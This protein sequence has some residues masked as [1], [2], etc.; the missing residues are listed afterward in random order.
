MLRSQLGVEKSEELV[1]LRDRGDS[2]LASTSG[3]SLF[4]RHTRWQSLDPVDIGFLELLD[5]LTGVR[6]HAV[7]ESALPF[8]EEDVE[9]ER[10]LAAATEPRHDDHLIAGDLDGDVLEV[11]LARSV[12]LDRL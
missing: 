7:E 6:R 3:D 9:C 12:D 10:R 8:G 2:R 11:V 4:D 1:D 5:K